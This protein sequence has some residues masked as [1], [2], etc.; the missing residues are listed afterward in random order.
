MIK[1]LIGWSFAIQRAAGVLAA[2]TLIT[3]MILV[4]L[5]VTTRVLGITTTF[6]EEFIRY[7][8]IILVSLGMGY[9]LL[10]QDHVRAGGLSDNGVLARLLRIATNAISVV[11]LVVVIKSGSDF[12]QLSYAWKMR[13]ISD[14][15]VLLWPFQFILW[16]GFILLMMQLIA[17]TILLIVDSEMDRFEGIS[18]GEKHQ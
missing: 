14:W 16:I 2:L 10:H 3:L 1:R 6:S 15:S 18:P 4:M 8:V 5:S 13:S 7:N 12:W 17:E 11:V 9:T